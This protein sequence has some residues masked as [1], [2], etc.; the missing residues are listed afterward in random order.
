VRV[1][2]LDDAAAIGEALAADIIARLKAATA[3]GRGLVLGCPTGRSPR[4][5]YQ[6]LG[7]RLQQA[8]LDLR[9]LTLVMMDEFIAS[10]PGGFAWIDDRAHNSCR[11]YARDEIAAPLNAGL[12]PE[13]RLPEDQIWFP[14]P[15]APDGAYD[16]RIAS[17]G[18]IDLFI[19]ASGA[20][21]G[22]VAFN[23]PGS[24]ADSRTRT[25]ALA[26]QTRRDNLASFPDFPGLEAVPYHGVTVGIATIARLSRAA[27]MVLWGPGK[28][29]AFSRI[30]GASGYDPSWPATVLSICSESVLLADRAASTP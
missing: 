5:V 29:T 7:H 28:R 13:W 15:S 21:D 22:H 23:P 14:D 2:I 25:V 17:A 20:G 10:S 30:A 12:P 24:P 6:A 4:P 18:G 26:E 1:E 11:R 3:A 19:L 27:T 9:R 16:E 8:P